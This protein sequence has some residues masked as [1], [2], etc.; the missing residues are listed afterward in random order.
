MIQDDQHSREMLRS[1]KKGEKYS[2]LTQAKRSF[3]KQVTDETITNDYWS[4]F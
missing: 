2:S 3:H 1:I 4:T